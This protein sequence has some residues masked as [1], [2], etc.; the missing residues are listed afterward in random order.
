MTDAAETI[1][2]FPR[3]ADPERLGEAQHSR[4]VF[5]YPALAGTTVDDLLTPP[6]WSLLASKLKPLDRIECVDDD[7]TYFAEFIVL[8]STGEGVRLALM[9]FGELQGTGPRDA[10]PRNKTGVHALYKGPHL[11]WCAFRGEALLKD[12]FESERDCLQWIAG[13]AKAAA[14]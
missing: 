3:R 13:H 11:R 4:R 2:N 9:R 6:Y 10:M 14:K 12:K 5:W 7:M 1:T 8:D